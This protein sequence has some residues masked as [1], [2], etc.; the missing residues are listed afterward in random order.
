MRFCWRECSERK[1]GSLKNRKVHKVKECIMRDAGAT[2]MGDKSAEEN[3]V[4]TE[5]IKSK[6][7]VKINF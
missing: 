5:K 3:E 4:E 1:A 7:N 6:R 2:K